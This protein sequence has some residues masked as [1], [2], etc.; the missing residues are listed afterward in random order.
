[1]SGS[2]KAKSVRV[3]ARTALVLGPD[4]PPVL[5]GC[6]VNL[7]ATEAERLIAEGH[8]EADPAAAKAEAEREAAK[9]AAKAEA[10]RQAA[11]AKAQAEAEREAAEAAA[12]AEAERQAAEAKAKAEAEA[13]VSAKK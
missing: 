7:P 2:I 10:E 9:A 1:M 11:E 8:A 5:P 3:I 12:K 13:G 4:E 6:P